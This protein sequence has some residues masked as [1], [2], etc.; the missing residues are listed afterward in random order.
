MG[1]GKIIFLTSAI[2]RVSDVN[3]S[4]AG[5]SELSSVPASF[6]ASLNT[7]GNEAPTTAGGVRG[8]WLVPPRPAPIDGFCGPSSL[9]TVPFFGKIASAGAH[10]A[11]LIAPLM[12]RGPLPFP[13]VAALLRLSPRMSGGLELESLSSSLV[14]ESSLLDVSLLEVSLL[15][16]SS[17][18]LL[19]VSADVVD[20]SS[21]LL[22][23]SPDSLLASAGFRVLGGTE[24]TGPTALSCGDGDGANIASCIGSE[25]RCF[26]AWSLRTAVSPG[27]PHGA[28]EG[29]RVDPPPPDVGGRA[30]CGGFGWTV[31]DLPAVSL[32]AAVTPFI[33][34]LEVF[35]AAVAARAATRADA[36]R[37]AAV[38]C[39]SRKKRS[40]RVRARY[41]FVVGR[42]GVYAR[43]GA[44]AGSDGDP[45]G[46]RLRRRARNK[47]K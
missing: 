42:R 32:A 20:V 28:V 44:A 3:G 23:M 5:M 11:A 4:P 14:E 38:D 37:V 30:E 13:A 15:D 33:V 39:L 43:S 2:V 16:V 45:L 8:R 27:D 40:L 10:V 35:L 19:F 46:R 9:S 24:F 1:F 29:T 18:L 17:L 6:E 7:S 47:S 34:L 36:R 21:N 12:G 31:C 41:V 26:V 25:G 22:A